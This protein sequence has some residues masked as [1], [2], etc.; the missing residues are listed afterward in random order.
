M[1]LHE[2][3]ADADGCRMLSRTKDRLKQLPWWRKRLCITKNDVRWCSCR[4]RTSHLMFGDNHKQRWPI[5]SIQ[6]EH[7]I[8]AHHFVL[9]DPRPAPPNEGALEYMLV[10]RGYLCDGRAAVVVASGLRSRCSLN[11]TYSKQPLLASCTIHSC[12]VL[13]YIYCSFGCK[14]E[15]YT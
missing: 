10:E 3:A 13:K 9:R 6:R 7:S 12:C 1:V 4:S 14:K 8:V 2:D 5:N 15:L 11:E